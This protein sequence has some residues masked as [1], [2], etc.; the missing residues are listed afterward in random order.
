MENNSASTR[1]NEMKNE[2]K[3]EKSKKKITIEVDEDDPCLKKKEEEKIYVDIHTIGD[4]PRYI[5]I[6]FIIRYS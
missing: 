1:K 2:M 5:Y 3:N 4:D 6:K